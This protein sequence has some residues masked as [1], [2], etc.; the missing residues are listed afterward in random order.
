MM[1]AIKPSRL[2]PEPLEPQRR[3]VP[4]LRRKQQQHPYKGIA[5]ETTA[6]LVVNILL[7]ATA[8][9]ALGQ[10]ISYHISQETKLGE[11]KSEVKRTEKRVEQLRNN[12]NRYFD[13]QQAKTIMQEQ[14]YRVDPNKQQVILLDKDTADEEPAQLP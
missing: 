10:L 6:K 12:F 13:P 3:T 2:P 7:S 1:N 14:G 9:A 11:I 8:I 4:R 5:L